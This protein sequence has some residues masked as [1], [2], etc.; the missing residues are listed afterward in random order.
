MCGIIG[1]IGNQNSVPILIDGLKRLEYRG[2]DSAGIAFIQHEKI[3]VRRC[4]G[5]L[6][7]L[8]MA[9]SGEKLNST[10]GIGHTRWATHGRPSE[11]N[12]HP[13]RVGNIVVVH[14]GIIE[15]YIQLKKE[16]IAEGRHFTSETDTE[17]IAHLIER[18]T[19]RGLTLVQ[20]VQE[21]LKEVKGA[22]A[23]AVLKEEEPDILVGA[24]NGCPLVAGLAQGGS[25]LAS[26]IPAILNYTRDV[27]F[28][29]DEE[30][31]ILSTEGIQ[32]V[33]LEGN[34]VEKEPS[35]VMWNPV[36]AEKG[37]Y[38]HFMLKEIYEQ[39]RAIM[40][41][42]RGR[43]SYDTGN[44]YLDEAGL[45]EDDVKGLKKIFIVACGTSW[46]AAL[47]AKFM[48]EEIARLP[49][50]VDVGSEFRYRNPLIDGK[51]LLIAITQSGET[52]DTLAAMREAK[53][54]G[55]KVFSVCNVVGST[56]ARESD[57]IIYTHAGPEIGVA[58][59]KTFTAQ[60]VALYIL[61]IY[62]G[63]ARGL[64][65]QAE[66]KNKLETLSQL[67][68]LV[69]KILEDSD[70]IEEMAR[71]YFQYTDFLYLGRGPNYPIALEGALKLKEI[72]YIHAEGYPAGEMKHGPIAL[73]DDKMPTVALITRNNV[74]DKVISNIMEVKARGG[75]VIA[76]A[77]DGDEDI[78][79]KADDVVYLPQFDHLLTPVLLA[80]PLQLFAYHIAV[81]RGCDVDQPRNLAKSVTVE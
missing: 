28:L 35:K 1:Y 48:I 18:H 54:K 72:S 20:A 68:N 24:R 30:I 21:A 71:R 57:G 14:N 41:T 31:I 80:I 4:V 29:N 16:L 65:S 40:D 58:A 51:S 26:A 77:T 5:K 13:H 27:L 75:K 17:V 76:I 78:S 81:L 37:G 67:H 55:G 39:P 36:M 60:L 2:Y 49:V 10:I 11:E 43:L 38:R 69:E 6:K 9:L 62:L 44:V 7:N 45:S 25:F 74:Y 19:K 73:I 23:I 59:T 33:D 22:Y 64:L 8:E 15:N 12:A 79:A 50:E 70:R 46:H 56:A 61:A 53:G 63:R 47:V 3:E 32:I 42:L 52:A 34:P 66:G